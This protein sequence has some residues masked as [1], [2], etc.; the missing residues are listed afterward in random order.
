MARSDLHCQS[1]TWLLWQCPEFP[2][3][4][5]PRDLQTF[6][7]LSVQFAL[8]WL[9]KSIF[10]TTAVKYSSKVRFRHGHAGRRM[11]W[12]GRDVLLYLCAAGALENNKKP[13]TGRW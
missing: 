12:K 4:V 13:K 9:I 3:Q 6:L 1:Y 10:R 2:C 11:L 7:F 5:V 8:R